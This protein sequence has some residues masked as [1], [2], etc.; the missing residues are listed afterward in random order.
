M[1]EITIGLAGDLMLGRLVDEFLQNVT[2]AYVWGD[3]LPFFRSTDFNLLNL[4]CAF[5]KSEKHVPKVFNFKSDPKNV[6]VLREAKIDLVN[7]A[8]NHT[9]DYSEEGLLETL[10]TLEQAEISFVGAGRRWSQA[11]S[12]AIF[13]RE[14]IK[15]A[16]LGCTDNEP[17]WKAG[18]SKPGIFYLKVGDGS[19]IFDSIAKLRPLVD[20]LILS[21]HWG[22]N[23]KERPSKEFKEFAHELLERG[24]DIIHGHSAHIFQG[25][26]VYKEKKL[27]LYDTGDFVDDYAVDPYLRNDLSFFFMVKANV[28][29]LLSLQLIP[30]QISNF[31]VNV[32][33]PENAQDMLKRMQDLS[34]EFGTRLKANMGK[35]E[36]TF[37]H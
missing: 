20:L 11:I 10:S 14:G 7:L 16:V 24:V 8:N 33:K 31:Q 30:T 17:T 1:N 21:I 3:L 29:G 6:E 34:K 12:P 25:I 35:L 28:K 9:L 4:E 22:P 32:M 26:E 13:E 36:F 23:M 2:P 18:I 19:Q 5:T 15:I 37:P 27:I